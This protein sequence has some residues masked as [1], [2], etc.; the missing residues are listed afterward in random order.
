MPIAVPKQNAKTEAAAKGRFPQ[1]ARDASDA[2]ASDCV[3]SGRISTKET[4]SGSF[5]ESHLAF[6]HPR[7][8]L[9]WL[10]F[11]GPGGLHDG[12]LARL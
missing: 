6:E 10:L 8:D 5:W 3:D 9:L 4:D 2:D 7:A 11:C 1:L 12:H